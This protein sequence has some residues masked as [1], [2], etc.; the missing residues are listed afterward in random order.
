MKHNNLIQTVVQLYFGYLSL[1]YPMNNLSVKLD[2][3]IQ[4][5]YIITF[6]MAVMETLNLISVVI[7]TNRMK[8]IMVFIRRIIPKWW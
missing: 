8:K 6:V 4:G 1:N 5:N 7:T 2:D 3:V